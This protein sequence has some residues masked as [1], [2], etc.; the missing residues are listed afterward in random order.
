MLLKTCVCC[1]DGLLHYSEWPP[2]FAMGKRIRFTFN[3]VGGV[4]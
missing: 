1:G 2:G 3:P 4:K